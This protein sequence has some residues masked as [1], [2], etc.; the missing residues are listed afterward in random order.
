MTQ[1]IIRD[2]ARYLAETFVVVLLAGF[3]VLVGFALMTTRL[4]NPPG[5][6]YLWFI[7]I[8]AGPI[9]AGLCLGYVINRRVLSRTAAWVW[10]LPAIWLAYGAARYRSSGEAVLSY[11]WNDVILGNAEGG[12]IAQLVAGAPFLFSLAYSFGAWLALRRVA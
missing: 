7:F 12:M 2:M 1:T 9:L 6:T 8:L 3:G 11:L 5:G 10:I 4:L